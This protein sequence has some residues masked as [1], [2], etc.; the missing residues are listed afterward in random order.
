M[1]VL[2]DRCAF[3]LKSQ[4]LPLK[5]INNMARFRSHSILQTA[6][7]ARLNFIANLMV[8]FFLWMGVYRQLKSDNVMLMQTNIQAT[9]GLSVVR[10]VPMLTV[11]LGKMAPRSHSMW[12][13]GSV[14]ILNCTLVKAIRRPAFWRVILQVKK[15]SSVGASA[16]TSLTFSKFCRRLLF[17]AASLQ[18]S[19][20]HDEWSAEAWRAQL[21]RNK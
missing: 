7:G 13:H 4:T 5:P 21:N 6:D 12:C 20:W 10:T 14:D 19:V 9:F 17:V 1:P 18:K 11:L 2:I 3:C 16:F 8:F 15:K